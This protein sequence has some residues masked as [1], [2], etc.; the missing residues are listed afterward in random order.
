LIFVFFNMWWRF[1]F[2]NKPYECM[3]LVLYCLWYFT[4]GILK[5]I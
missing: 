5:K 4:M 2:P 3:W 1:C